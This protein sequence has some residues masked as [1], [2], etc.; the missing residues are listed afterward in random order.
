MRPIALAALMLTGC[1]WFLMETPTHGR[2]PRTSGSEVASNSDVAAPCTTSN[3]APIADTV[4][5]SIALAAG[6]GGIAAGA[7]TKPDD[8]I[9]GNT[10]K[11]G[12]YIGGG[13]ALAEAVVFTASAIWGYRTAATCRSQTTAE[14][15]AAR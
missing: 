12:F 3:S 14:A 11:D 10:F 15:F 2:A 1:S 9:F 6:V 4:I 8:W 13:V 5:A 7:A